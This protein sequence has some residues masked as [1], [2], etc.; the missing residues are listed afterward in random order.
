MK[1]AL[2]RKWKPILQSGVATEEQITQYLEDVEEYRDRSPRWH[3][4]IY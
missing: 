4:K 1:I 2:V 3:H